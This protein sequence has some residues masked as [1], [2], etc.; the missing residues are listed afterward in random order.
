MSFF[1][2]FSFLGFCK[3][4]HETPYRSTIDDCINLSP[5]LV[6]TKNRKKAF[7]CF[8]KYCFLINIAIER[9]NLLGSLNTIVFEALMNVFC[10]RVCL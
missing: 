5:D 4:I 1:S 8:S 3:N 6:G 9:L 7:Y 10:D 2:F